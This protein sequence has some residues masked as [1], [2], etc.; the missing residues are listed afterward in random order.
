[1][2]STTQ[3]QP[4]NINT[5]YLNHRYSIPNRNETQYYT[6]QQG[7]FNTFPFVIPTPLTPYIPS[8][9]RNSTLQLDSQSNTWADR[10]GHIRS[11]P[12]QPRSPPPQRQCYE[13][14]IIDEDEEIPEEAFMTGTEDI[15]EDTT[16]QANTTPSSQNYTP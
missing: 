4:Q 7:E 11:P 12:P 9:H 3:S 2:S 1:M 10:P 13:E 6:Q 5:A 8:H 16:T 14:T 15:S